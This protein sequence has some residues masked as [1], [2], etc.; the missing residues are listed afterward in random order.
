MEALPDRTDGNAP[1]LAW[2]A[3]PPW[4]ACLVGPWLWTVPGTVAILSLLTCEVGVVWYD[5]GAS[6]ADEHL[7]VHS[8]HHPAT[9]LALIILTVL[10]LAAWLVWVRAQS[11]RQLSAACLGP[12]DDLSSVANG[13]VPSNRLF[14]VADSRPYAVCVGLWRPTIC[15]SSGLLDL[16]TPM[17]LRAVLAHEEMHRLRRDPLRLHICQRLQCYLPMV[18]W[19]AELPNRVQL[20][21]E[22][23]ADR[24][25]RGT[26]KRA[27][28]ATALL[29]L[30]RA[31]TRINAS[32]QNW[33]WSGRWSAL[34]A[35]PKAM[36]PVGAQGSGEFVDERICYLL[37]S[38]AA[39]LPSLVAPHWRGAVAVRLTLLGL[40]H[41]LFVSP[42]N[43][44]GFHNI[45]ALLPTAPTFLRILL[46]M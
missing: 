10:T 17:Q 16:L 32:A 27:H 19:L 25:A 45:L 34:T 21:A 9:H 24:A 13:L 28:L 22:I 5:A 35:E 8:F 44:V 31:H 6:R 39:P 29:E 20:R 30:L 36:L 43:V 42:A 38:E 40:A 11:V 18:P 3:E 23:Q 7:I 15:V 26:V 37:S 2:L 12:S 33:E 41:L 14:V 46:H 1:D 4:W